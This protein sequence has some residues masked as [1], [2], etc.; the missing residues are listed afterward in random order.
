MSVNADRQWPERPAA[1]E[2][3]ASAPWPTVRGAW[4]PRGWFA[5]VCLVLFALVTADLFAD[6][7]LR[8]VDHLIAEAMTHL[9]IRH[10]P[11]IGVIGYVLTQTGGRGPNLILLLL[12]SGV[13]AVTQRTFAP[14]VRA[15]LATGLLSVIMLA[16][17]P[18]FGRT[19]PAYGADL[20]H[21]AN[22][23]SYPSGHQANA[24]LL[25]AVGAW[26]AADYVHQLWL[27]RCA[28]WYAIIAPITA[29]ISV[30]LMNYH[31][32]SDII[33]GAS[34]G[35]CLLWILRSVFATKVGVQFERALGSRPTSSATDSQR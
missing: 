21:N 7:F 33:A 18:I 13:I 4:R 2:P 31:W 24:I 3:G 5:L 19:A 1:S 6:G 9:D 8:H 20:L 10:R 23:M 27:R 17:K 28:F 25:S 29:S 35:V 12:L 16:A 34:L 15:L 11:A 22:G 32:L 14:L 26:I 30:L